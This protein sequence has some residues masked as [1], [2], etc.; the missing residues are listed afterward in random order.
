MIAMMMGLWLTGEAHASPGVNLYGSSLANYFYCDAW[1]GDGVW[2]GVWLGNSRDDVS[3]GF[4]VDLFQD[5]PG[6]PAPGQLSENYQ[7]V[8]GLAGRDDGG[9]W[10]KWVYFQLD[11]EDGWSGWLDVSID[12]TRAISETSESDNIISKYI[13]VDC[14]NGS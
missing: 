4:W 5:L 2:V 13:V 12:S 14:S 1:P 6:P 9:G 8:T 3:R 7:W 10:S 11:A